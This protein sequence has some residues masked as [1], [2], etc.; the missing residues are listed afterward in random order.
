VG[1]FKYKMDILESLAV[2]QIPR[3]LIAPTYLEIHAI[4]LNPDSVGCL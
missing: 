1:G 2:T 4:S 3:K